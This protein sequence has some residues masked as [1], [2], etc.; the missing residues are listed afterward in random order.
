MTEEQFKIVTNILL[1]ILLCVAIIA[2]DA[3]FS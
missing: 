1:G 3:L 2:G